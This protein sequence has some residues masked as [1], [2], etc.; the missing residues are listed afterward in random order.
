[1]KLHLKITVTAETTLVELLASQ[2]ELSKSVIKK[3][4]NFGG[5]W[6]RAGGKGSPQRCRRATKVLHK[7]DMVEF[8]FDDRLYSETPPA[9]RLI[10]ANRHWGVW[11]KPANVVAQGTPYGDTGCMEQQVQALGDQKQV[12]LIHRLD[13]EAAG[14]MMFAYHRQAA[15]QLSELWRSGNATKIYQAEIHGHL[16]SSTG[17]IEEPLDGKAASTRFEVI[18]EKSHSTLMRIHLETGR[19]H[20]IRRHF[21]HIGHPLIG[22]PQY[23]QGGGKQ[24]L[25]LIASELHF[26]CPFDGKKHSVTLPTELRLF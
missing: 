1:M 26:E 12:F 22:D 13:R 8:F 14:L 19:F 18:E 25:Q 17:R 10:Q 23:G 5:G 15:A 4:L 11:Y 20:Q 16:E 9:A 7:G 2:S 21:A 3:A 6:L 24:P